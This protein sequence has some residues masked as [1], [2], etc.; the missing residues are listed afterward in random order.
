MMAEDEIIDK[1]TIIL[2]TV[3]ALP[4]PILRFSNVIRLLP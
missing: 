2:Q 1:Q 4:H 3:A